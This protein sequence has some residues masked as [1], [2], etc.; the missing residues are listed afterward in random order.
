MAG[1]SRATPSSASYTLSEM[2]G[3]TVGLLDALG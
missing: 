3:D 2:A 1:R